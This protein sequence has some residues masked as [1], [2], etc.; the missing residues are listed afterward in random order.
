ME[1]LRLWTWM[2]SRIWVGLIEGEN[3]NEKSIEDMTL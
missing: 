1:I 2:R 3:T